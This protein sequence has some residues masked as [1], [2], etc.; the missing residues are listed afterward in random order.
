MRMTQVMWK[1]DLAMNSFQVLQ[2]D[3]QTRPQCAYA[4]PPPPPPSSLAGLVKSTI[5]RNNCFYE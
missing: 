2:V 1:F 3:K 4:P 5:K